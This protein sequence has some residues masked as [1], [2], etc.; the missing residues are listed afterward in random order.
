M[1]RTFLGRTF[2][3][4]TYLLRPK[5]VWLRLTTNRYNQGVDNGHIAAQRNLLA[6][7]KTH[8]VIAEKRGAEHLAGYDA[9]TRIV[10]KQFAWLNNG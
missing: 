9:A 7:L 1:T 10:K 8:R 5:Q 3:G 6:S 4:W 2:Y